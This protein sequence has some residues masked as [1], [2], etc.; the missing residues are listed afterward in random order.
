MEN[1]TQPR[2]LYY[3]NTLSMRLDFL[4][5]LMPLVGDGIAGVALEEVGLGYVTL[6]H[7]CVRP[8]LQKY[9]PR[10]G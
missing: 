10:Y 2:A 9:S 3:P 6:E 8:Q 4:T 7:R 5:R 1:N